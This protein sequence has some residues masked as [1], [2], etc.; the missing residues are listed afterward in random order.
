MLATYHTLLNVDM[1]DTDGVLIFDE[2]GFI[3]KGVTIQVAR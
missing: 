1:G 3:K 2:S